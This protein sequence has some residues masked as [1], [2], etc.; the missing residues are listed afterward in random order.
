MP[1]VSRFRFY[2]SMRR[3]VGRV[4]DNGSLW[5]PGEKETTIGGW[6][7]RA[8]CLYWYPLNT[9][10]EITVYPLLFGG[11]RIVRGRRDDDTWEIG[12]D[13]PD[14]PTAIAAAEKW[15]GRDDPG[16]GWLKKLDPSE[17][18]TNIRDEL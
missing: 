1:A 11:A 4:S 2:I 7:P 8:G 14:H 13:Y 10:E 3:T 18:Q 16:H 15:N 12:Y 6:I 9:L 5:T 17:R